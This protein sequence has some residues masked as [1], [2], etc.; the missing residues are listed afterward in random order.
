MFKNIL[1]AVDGTDQS[2]KAVQLA[3]DLGERYGASL[4]FLHVATDETVS[5]EEMRMVE[6]EHLSDIDTDLPVTPEYGRAGDTLALP[7]FL[8]RAGVANREVR[9][10]IGR[11]L[12][13]QAKGKAEEMGVAVAETRVEDGSP[14]ETILKVAEETGADAIVMGSRGRSDLKGLVLGSVSHAVA[15]HA[16]ASVVT[17]R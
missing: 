8:A 11:R 5:E 16:K 12:V 6:V 10:A 4:T 2:D 13:A 7:A 9:E 17:V 1:V 15:S 3:C 14:A